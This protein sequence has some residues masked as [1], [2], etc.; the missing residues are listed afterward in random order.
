MNM[1]ERIARINE[2]YHKSQ[3]EG[4][5]KEEKEEQASLRREYID[6]VKGSLK[7]QLDNVDIKE[8]DGSITNLGASI[9]EKK[10]RKDNEPV[11]FK[12]AQLR[13]EFLKKRDSMSRDEILK[14]SQLI[15][16]RLFIT[17]EYREAELILL[18]ASYGS[19]VHT[20]G[21]ME[22]ALKDGK[23]VAF[24]KCVNVD[25]SPSME[26]YEVHSISEL[27]DG[28]KG[29]LEPDTQNHSLKKVT[30]SA[31]LCIVPGVSFTRR[32]YR[33]GYGKGFYDRY[34]RSGGAK[35]YIGIS[36]KSQLTHDFPTD[37]TDM[38]VDALIT[39]DSIYV[40]R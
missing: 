1:E 9:R 10:D 22:R 11:N 20:F 24:P 3:K 34:I 32:G 35:K 5:T 33:I 21:I 38:A 14:K 7:N 27:S 29:I 6:S 23:R 37:E 40:C 26:F 15:E 25:G 19:E 31:D 2:L 18:Y 39:E 17:D 8:K 30:G 28:Y 16:S 36:F 13:K 12:K 4:L